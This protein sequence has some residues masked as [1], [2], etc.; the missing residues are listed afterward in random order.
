[1]VNQ[2]KVSPKDLLGLAFLDL[3]WNILAETVVNIQS[4]MRGAQDFRLFAPGSGSDATV[5]EQGDI[6]IN[7]LDLLMP[8]RLVVP[9]RG[10]DDKD[11]IMTTWTELD[12]VF[13]EQQQQSTTPGLRVWVAPKRT[14][15]APCS[16]PRSCGKNFHFFGDQNNSNLW[17]EVWPSA[18]HLIRRVSD[19]G[20]H[21]KHEPEQYLTENAPYP[22]FEN[23]DITTYKDKETTTLPNRR[24]A[25]APSWLTRGRGSACCLKI[26][27]PQTGKSLWMGIAHSKTLG[28]DDI[29]PNHY[30]ST[31]YAFED[32]PPFALVAQSGYFCLPFPVGDDDSSSVTSPAGHMM[33][34]TRWRI[35]RLGNGEEYPNCPRIHFVSG[36]VRDANDDDKV[37][38]AYG[39]ND[40]VSRLVQ[41][42]LSDLVRLLFYRLPT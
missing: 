37:I 24:H 21:R 11:V 14:R 32:T 39:L 23:R 26:Q 19:D 25:K 30:L 22:S 3:E 29:Q 27:H 28:G 36:L 41:V 13:E 40:C 16:K 38:V 5:G 8:L 18:P 1:M 20:C 4:V 7:S 33:N 2:E 12:T 9:P 10:S 42:R 15:C 34:I 6:Y 31:L 35:L 17:A